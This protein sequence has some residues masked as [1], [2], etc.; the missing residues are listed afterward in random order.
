MYPYALLVFLF[1]ILLL[2]ILKFVFWIRFL[3]SLAGVP[4]NTGE[5]GGGS[6]K[7]PSYHHLLYVCK[8]ANPGFKWLQL[9]FTGY[10]FHDNSTGGIWVEG[11]SPELTTNLIDRYVYSTIHYIHT[12]VVT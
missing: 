8:L 7:T 1:F 2:F 5:G 6:G 12:Y 3:T 9:I 4:G 11:F 10:E